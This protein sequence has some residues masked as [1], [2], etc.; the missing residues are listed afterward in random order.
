[1]VEIQ[2]HKLIN[3]RNPWNKSLNWNGRWSEAS[4]LWTPL[5]RKVIDPKKDYE[6]HT[7][8]M[9]FDDFVQH[10]RSLN[11]SRVKNWEEVR[12]RGKFL[13][14]LDKNNPTNEIVLSRWYYTVIYTFLI[15]AV[16]RLN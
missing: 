16:F 3:I 12:L 13:R 15:S 14:I 10:F 8:W 5:I 2:G 6:S 1:M 4:V 9:C 11:I 7:F